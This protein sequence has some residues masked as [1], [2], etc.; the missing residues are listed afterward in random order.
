MSSSSQFIK[1]MRQCRKKH[2]EDLPQFIDCVRSNYER[3]FPCSEKI[4]EEAASYYFGMI[5]PGKTVND[6]TDLATHATL[7]M[8]LFDEVYQESDTEF[9]NEPEWVFVQGLV[10]D[11]ALELEEETIMYIMNLVLE[12]GFFN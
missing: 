11:F 6:Y 1:H 8:D 2:S 5:E 9:L 12:K 3:F 4:A 10:N 7:M